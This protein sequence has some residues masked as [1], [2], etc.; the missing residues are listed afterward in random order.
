M[1]DV[2]DA[3]QHGG[4][5]YQSAVINVESSGNNTII[6]APGTGQRLK[7]YAILLTVGGAVNVRWESGASG[8]A[9]TGVT[10]L[11]DREGY[12][13]SVPPPAFLFECADNALLNLELSASINVD[14]FVS[15]WD[16]DG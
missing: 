10:E 1:A 13:I 3:G 11:E 8:T 5:T 9:L 15:Y 2:S 12:S 16:D 14:G 7:I 6:S 4:H